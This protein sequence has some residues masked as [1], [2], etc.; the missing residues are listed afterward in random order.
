MVVVKRAPP[1]RTLILSRTGMP[2][3]ALGR[4]TGLVSWKL[5]SVK[6]LCLTPSVLGGGASDVL[7]G[8]AIAAGRT[9]RGFLATFCSTAV[10][11]GSESRRSA[12]ERLSKNPEQSA[13]SE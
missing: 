3:A 10:H 13:Y 5:L 2:G 6:E 12:T 4:R 1:E 11:K 7:D 9:G 8:R